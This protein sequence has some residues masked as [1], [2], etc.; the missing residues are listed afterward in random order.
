MPRKSTTRTRSA[1]T[2]LIAYRTLVSLGV[3]N[4]TASE[5]QL[6]LIAPPGTSHRMVR[7]VLHQIAAA[8]EI[9]TLRRGS[10]GWIVRVEHGRT[11]ENG[12]V[13]L[14]LIDGDPHEAG[15]AL[16]VLHAVAARAVK[17]PAKAK[18]GACPDCTLPRAV[19]AET[20]G[21]AS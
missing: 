12:F 13:V 10:D 16:A 2:A 7:A 19:C 11:S 8:A 20:G 14:E 21:C 9:E 18:R 6:E 4:Y 15:R 17:P 5:P 3:T 1:A